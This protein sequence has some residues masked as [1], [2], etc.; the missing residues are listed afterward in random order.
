[1]T[2][3]CVK[4]SVSQIVQAADCRPILWLFAGVM[5]KTTWR[6]ESHRSPTGQWEHQ[7]QTFSNNSVIN[8]STICSLRKKPVA[9]D[10]TCRK[11]KPSK[12]ATADN[13]SIVRA[14]KKSPKTSDV[15]K[16]AHRAE[17]AFTMHHSKKMFQNKHRHEPYTVSCE[18]KLYVLMSLNKKDRTVWRK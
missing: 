11:A 7:S 1:M 13:K 15:T 4:L 5:D 9:C 6:S 16:N 12:T 18:S 3:Q 8:N 2:K 14:V 17:V 10:A